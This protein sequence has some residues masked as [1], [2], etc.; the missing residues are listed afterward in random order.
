MKMSHVSGAVVACLLW[1]TAFAAVKLG[2]ED[3]SKPFTFA[4]I[5][6]IISGL[7]L[8]PFWSDYRAGFKS[9]AG[10]YQTVLLTAF[11]NTFVLYALFFKGLDLVPGAVAAIVTGA[12]PLIAAVMG[13]F[14]MPEERLS[15]GKFFA[16]MVGMCGLVLITLNKGYADRPA[17][18]Q[19]AGIAMLFA[20]SCSSVFG[21]ILV[22]KTSSLSAINPLVLN[23]VQLF[24]GGLGL[25]LLGL[26]WEGAPDIMNRSSAFY[27]ALLWLSLLS[28]VAFSIWFALLTQPEVK[29]SDL[30]QWKFLV[31]M[32]GAAFSW[33][34][35]PDE[36]PGFHTIS[37]MAL[38]V[39]ALLLYY[40]RRA[41]SS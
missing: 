10:C 32:F 6:F 15:R 1:S 3:Y 31:P 36:H 12:A 25:L 21:N 26:V 16:V 33:L 23:S 8:L 9:V 2:L 19:L 5:R 11:F 34:I 30:N 17:S 13:H 29:V 18:T 37:G 40:R 7:L 24:L 41:T 38:I 4:G 27:L 35:L 22:S 14:L 39:T 20:A 28:A